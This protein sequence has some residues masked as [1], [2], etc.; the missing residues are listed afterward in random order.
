[1]EISFK[2]DE[3]DLKI[4]LETKPLEKVRPGLLDVTYF[5][6][7]IRVVI[8]NEDLFDGLPSRHLS[9]PLLSWAAN[10]FNI[11]KK[12]PYLKEGHLILHDTGG[13]IYFKY[14]ENNT[15]LLTYIDGHINKTIILNYAELLA[16]FEVFSEQVKAFLRERAPEI[17]KNPVW[18]PWVK[19]LIDEETLY[20]NYNDWK[21]PRDKNNNI[22]F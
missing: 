15:T 1:M 4:S 7:P 13:D 2:V 17:E 9:M 14:L 6:M 19:G 11:V 16:S 3:E 22:I 20:K 21:P 12:L 10:G 5:L 18:G 8:N